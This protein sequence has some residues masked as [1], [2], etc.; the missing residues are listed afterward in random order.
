[1]KHENVFHISVTISITSS[2][3]NRMWIPNDCHLLFSFV[4]Y[5]VFDA[6]KCHKTK[7]E[8]CAWLGEFDYGLS[9][10]HATDTFHWYHA[11]IDTQINVKVMDLWNKASARNMYARFA[12]WVCASVC[13]F[14][15]KVRSKSSIVH[16]VARTFNLKRYTMLSAMPSNVKRPTHIST[17]MR[18]RSEKKK[19]KKIR[20]RVRIQRCCIF[21]SNLI[22]SSN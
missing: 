11:E 5:F 10:S 21:D 12:T 4:S 2:D 3:G 16:F 20:V 19:E 7:Q 18:R 17:T 22:F 15:R 1:M 13:V 8:M 6:K 14:G 9:V